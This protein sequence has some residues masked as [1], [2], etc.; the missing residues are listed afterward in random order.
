MKRIISLVLSILLLG[1]L[2]ACIQNVGRHAD[3]IIRVDKATIEIGS[4]HTDFDGMEI[5]IVNAVWN[6]EETKLDVNWINK[7]GPEVVNG[8]SYDIER[9]DGGKWTS[10]VTL[11]NLAFN[12]IGY[13]LKS[14][15]TQK[16]TYKLTDIFDISENGQYRFTTDCFVY[17]KGRGGESTE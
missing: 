13:E 15:A 12:S 4:T 2:T 11:D 6:D 5:Q 3:G 17:D 7:T 10:C 14:G 1:M 9:E 8:H 16:K